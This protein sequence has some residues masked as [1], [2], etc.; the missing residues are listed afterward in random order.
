MKLYPVYP[1]NISV[2]TFG[3]TDTFMI[4][5]YVPAT[6]TLVPI[7]VGPTEAKAVLMAKEGIGGERPLTHKLIADLVASCGC[8]V[9]NVYIESFSEGIF[10]AKIS[11]IGLMGQRKVDCRPSDAIAIAINCNAPIY[12]T[13]SLLEEAG[14][15]DSDMESASQL[16][17]PT[18]EELRSELAEAEANEEY[19]R[20]AEIMAE[21]NNRF[22]NDN[23]D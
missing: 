21:I 23:Q 19:E 17:Q 1:N 11:L 5:I 14:I 4:L 2:Q 20:A 10:Y 18:L 12:L 15:T 6:E 7:V 22:G 16:I 3:T 9:E 13:D 8:V